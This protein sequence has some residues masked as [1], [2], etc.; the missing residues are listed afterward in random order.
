M[1]QPQIKPSGNIALRRHP[2]IVDIAIPA[3]GV[4]GIPFAAP[5]VWH[6]AH[7][8]NLRRMMAK[9]GFEELDYETPRTTGAVRSSRSGATRSTRRPV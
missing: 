1:T 4:V 2:A 6:A 9:A 7:A 5:R 8:N 3:P